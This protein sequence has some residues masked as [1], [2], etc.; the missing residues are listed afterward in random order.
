MKKMKI[1]NEWD[2]GASLRYKREN[3]ERAMRGKI[4]RGLVELITNSDDS[5]RDLEDEGAKITGKIRI[6]IERRKAGHSSLVVVKDRASGMDREQM[7]KNLG[8]L[9]KRTSGHEKG[10]LRR[11]LHGRGARDVAA[12]GTIHFESIK[13]DKYNHLIIPPSLKCHFKNPNPKKATQ[14]IRK[15]LGIPRGNGTLVTIEVG[16][17]FKIPLHETVVTYFPRYYSLRD[18]FSSSER[19]ITIVDPKKKERVDDLTYNFPEGDFV[20]DDSIEI[21]NYF[22]VNAHF[23]VKKHSSPFEQESLP[24]REGI[25]IKSGAA[26]HDCTYFQLDMEPLAWRFTGE[27]RCD[28]ID[29]LVREFDDREEQ[30]PDK[31][32]HPKN[33]PMRLLDPFRDGLILEHPFAQ[34]LYKKCRDILKLLIDEIK[35]AEQKTKRDVTDE[36]LDKKLKQLSKAISRIFEKR[37]IDLEEEIQTEEIDDSKIK[38]LGLGLHIIPP[39]E[40]PVFVDQ[41]KT[42]SVVIKHSESLDVSIPIKVISSDPENVSIVSSPIFIKKLSEDGKIGRTT[43]TVKSDKIGSEAIIEVIYDGYSNLVLVKTIELPEPEIPFGLSFEKLKYR[44][45]LNKVKTMVLRLN[46]KSNPPDKVVADVTSDNPEIII[47]GGGKC[48]LL[49]EKP[50][51]IFIGKIRAVGRQLKA[52]GTITAKVKY[53]KT[54]SCGVTVEEKEPKSGMNF[55]PPKPIE[56]DFGTVRYKWD[57]KEP[58]LLLI[59]AK[60][61]SIRRYLG[62]PTDKGY[63]GVKNP[64]Y[65]TVLADV[66]A[67]ALA[68]ILLEKQ[69]SR[70]GGVAEYT[71]IDAYFHRH[72]SEFLNITHKHLVTLMADGTA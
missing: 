26:I 44:L 35:K 42:F 46:S 56:D 6:E 28:Y 14:E 67:E 36:A 38:Q 17:R 23:I 33:N 29:K 8:E 62:E 70:E 57:D 40:Q 18:I 72:F 64:S 65:H 2:L 15:K 13:N 22:G 71:S 69:I 55:K 21:P 47:K 48:E 41:P 3:M 60:H 53:F 31:P 61:P 68:F 20:F 51:N 25:L 59:G 5:Y 43:F 9:G 12:F 16:K 66:I 45:A 7:F 30:N 34:V 37:L 63:P 24:F 50:H 19:N 54:S 39:E 11:G 4:E 1:P 32:N 58:Y 10:K 27:L 52:S 49:L